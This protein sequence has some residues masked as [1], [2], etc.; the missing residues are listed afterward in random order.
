MDVLE[1]NGYDTKMLGKKDYTSGSH[2]VRLVNESS[3]KQEHAF[4]L[5][6]KLTLAHN[7]HKS[8]F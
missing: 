6:S 7:T 8:F 1:K 4:I 3:L 2:S 5:L